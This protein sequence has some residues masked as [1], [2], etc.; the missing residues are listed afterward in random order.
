MQ[1]IANYGFDFVGDAPSEYGRMITVAQYLLL[2]LLFAV[3]PEKRVI[4]LR[5]AVAG[6]YSSLIE[7][8]DTHFIGHV[9]IEGGIGLGVQTDGVEVS[10][11]HSSEPGPGIPA[12]DLRDAQKMPG[13]APENKR[14]TREQ[15]I[16]P[17]QVGLSP[18]QTGVPGIKDAASR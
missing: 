1:Y 14:V 15:E 7:H 2:Q 3:L 11:T 18:A 13:V 10:I 8:E 16:T 6:P 17:L 4:Q 5:S 9:E 12:G